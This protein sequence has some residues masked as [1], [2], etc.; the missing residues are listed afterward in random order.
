MLRLRRDGAGETNLLSV[1]RAFSSASS[2]ELPLSRCSGRDI[3]C[4]RVMVLLMEFRISAS[5][6]S[7]GMSLISGTWHTQDGKLL[8]TK[9]LTAYH[10]EIEDRLCYCVTASTKKDPFHHHTT[11]CL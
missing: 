11:F 1:R 8:I 10:M 6:S 5:L 4:L 2:E 7:M 9:S 3:V